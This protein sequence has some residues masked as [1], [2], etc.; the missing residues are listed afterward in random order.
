MEEIFNALIDQYIDEK[1]GIAEQFLS[2]SLLDNLRTNLTKLYSGNQLHAARIGSNQHALLNKDTRS[3]IIYW[4]DRS[5]NDPFEN[6]FFDVMDAFVLHLN[7]TCYAGISDYEFHYTMYET[8]T[9]Y[10][11]HVDQFQ[12]NNSRQFSII[13]YLNEGWKSEDGGQLCIYHANETVEMIA[14]L[15]GKMVFFKSN[16]LPHEV[17]LNHRPRMSITGWLKSDTV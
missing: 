10:K 5:H 4:L 11:K 8:N 13:I 6:A 1:V 16:E 9:F 2:L 3:D 14:P 7:T 12:H 17:L 15:N